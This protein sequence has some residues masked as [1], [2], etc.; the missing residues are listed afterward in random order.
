M[1]I[2]WD[3]YIKIHGTQHQL[4]ICFGSIKANNHNNNP[5]IHEQCVTRY[6]LHRGLCLHVC[7]SFDEIIAIIKLGIW[8]WVITNGGL[9]LWLKAKQLHQIRYSIKRFWGGNKKSIKR[10]WFDN[11]LIRVLTLEE[12]KR[13]KLIKVSRIQRIH[14]DRD[15]EEIQIEK[16]VAY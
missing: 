11:W 9:C 7:V 13:T 1:R 4:Y 14:S 5:I 16:F 15:N 10:F 3:K 6:R 8:F 2:N 12:W